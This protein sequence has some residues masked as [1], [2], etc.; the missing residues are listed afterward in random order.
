MPFGV[1][2]LSIDNGSEFMADFEAECAWRGIALFV[3]PP[4]SPKLNGAV[5]RANRTHSEEFYEVTD[6]PLELAALYRRPCAV[7]DHLQHHPAH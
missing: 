3:L 5:E 4:R 2:A 6:A 7:G 1:R